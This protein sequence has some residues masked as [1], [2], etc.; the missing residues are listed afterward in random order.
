MIFSSISELLDLAHQENNPVL[1][2]KPEGTNV[3]E[4][5]I[6][7]I[8]F[9]VFYL[10]HTLA[11]LSASDIDKYICVFFFGRHSH[12]FNQSTLFLYF[13]VSKFEFSRQLLNQF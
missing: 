10:L 1:G 11:F 6:N 5:C 4:N 8:H 9:C 12:F 2:R 7:C 3:G 13:I